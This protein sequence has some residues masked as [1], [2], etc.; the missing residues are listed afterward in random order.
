M[1][2][3]SC[4]GSCT[5]PQI[6]NLT[7]AVNDISNIEVWNNCE[8]YD[9]ETLTWSYS[10]DNV[11]WS[12]YLSYN[13]ILKNTI[14][15]D[16]DFYI[17]I[18]VNG[19][20]SKVLI[21]GVETQNYKCSI[22]TGFNFVSCDGSVTSYSNL[23]N[24]YLNMECA[25]SLQQ[26]LTDSVTCIVGIPIYYF[27]LSGNK[28]SKDL[29]FKEYAL[30]DVESVKQI[31]LVVPD[32]QMPSSK[33]E[34]TDFGLD[35]QADWETEVSKSMF[36]TAFGNNAQPTEG[37]LI[38]IPMMKRMWMVNEAYEEKNEA[39][40]WNATTFKLA[41]VK[42]QEKGSVDLGN[43]EDLVNSFVKNKYEDLFGDEENVASNETSTRNP[44][45]KSNNLYPIYESDAVRKYI[46]VD[47]IKFNDNNYIYYRGTLISDMFY[48]F[49]D[50]DA[51]IIYQKTF[52]GN[53]GSCSFIIKTYTSDLE[54][55][56]IN[57]G[58]IQLCLKYSDKKSIL[59]LSNNEN[60]KVE[61]HNNETYF[62]YL[63]WSKD[64]KIV[65]LSAS[66]YT[67]PEGI[68]LYKLQ[69]YHYIFDIDNCLKSTG[70]WDIEFSQE[71]NQ[72][73]YIEGFSGI[74]SNFKLFDIYVDDVND[75]L[76]MYP[77]HQHLIINDT[78]RKLIDL[79]GLE[80][81]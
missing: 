62:V 8:A 46:T 75:L 47:Y 81:R 11:C 65:E 67:Y 48:S 43:T 55:S 34:F 19:L 14:D 21:D 22:A 18:K 20:V 70:K 9:N 6:I 27:K 33:P 15:L 32:G 59:Y 2:F 31:K 79:N 3:N 68:P 50:T 38:Y 73:V 51:K 30:M 49:S 35:W 69:P 13:E 7:Y 78:A 5:P 25:L 40:M 64:L 76:Q 23:Y 26:Y 52:C 80:L 63:R 16:T 44:V 1:E 74:M 45:Y 61:L 39:L 28:G 77:N 37:D 71:T 29:T 42:Y 58:S 36:A 54:V 60:I 10:L 12:C 66:I 57:I 24:P 4:L 56:F 17:R 53:S 72:E 41:L